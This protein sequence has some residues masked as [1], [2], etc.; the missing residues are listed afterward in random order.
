MGLPTDEDVE[1]ALNWMRENEERYAQA[2]ARE[3]T[4][5]ELQKIALSNEFL[6]LEGKGG[7]SEREHMS[8]ASSSYLAAVKNAEDMQTER[9]K[10][11]LAYKRAE[12]IVE[13]WRTLSA[14]QRRGV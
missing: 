14:N 5:K 3:T 8:R 6:Q 7:I 1:K 2:K 13:V 12:L 4:A 11:M 9:E 10:L